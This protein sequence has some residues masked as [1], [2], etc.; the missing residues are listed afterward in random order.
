MCGRFGIWA[1]KLAPAQPL[2]STLRGAVGVFRLFYL[3]RPA[4]QC[5]ALFAARRHGCDTRGLLRDGIF[6][7]SSASSLCP[8]RGLSTQAPTG[9]PERLCSQFRH[10]CTVVVRRAGAIDDLAAP[11]QDVVQYRLP[12]HEYRFR[13]ANSRAPIQADIARRRSDSQDRFGPGGRQ[14]RKPVS[15]TPTRQLDSAKSRRF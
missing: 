10:D 3:N 8:S 11:D 5:S 9:L 7:S 1:P 6:S 2:H 4:H 14:C 15:P 12:S 13:G